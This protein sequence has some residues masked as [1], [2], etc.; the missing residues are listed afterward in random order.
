M[1]NPP[2]NEH[3]SQVLSDLRGKADA[4]R[5]RIKTLT[6]EI[7]RLDTE[8][9]VFEN[10]ITVLESTMARDTIVVD[11]PDRIEH[12]PN[13]NTISIVFKGLSVRWSILWLLFD[14]VSNPMPVSEIA[15]TLR[16]RG[17]E[18]KSQNF[19]SNV[20]AVLSQMSAK[21]PPEVESDGGHFR[22]TKHG[23]E[24]WSG[25]QEAHPKFREHL[26]KLEAENR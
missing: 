25:I 4:A 2:N 24:I 13:V 9:E 8:A 19:N 6:A 18:S 11:V 16:Q 7:D 17:I 23:R 1:N 10:A 26:A 3:Y 21:D 14:Y 5:Q 15:Q 22:L 12:G 20:S